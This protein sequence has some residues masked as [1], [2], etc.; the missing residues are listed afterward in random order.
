MCTRN[1]SWLAANIKTADPEPP[2]AQENSKLT[3]LSIKA[4]DAASK[5]PRLISAEVISFNSNVPSV[6]PAGNEYE[7]HLKAIVDAQS[8]KAKSDVKAWSNELVSC[9][10]VDGMVQ[11]P[12]FSLAAKR[13][14]FLSL[15]TEYPTCSKV[16][17]L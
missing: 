8:A 4:E 12:Q 17:R 5:T 9:V 2:A 1:G 13:L 7:A 10:H 11:D 16:C 15:L 6:L 3:D 14:F